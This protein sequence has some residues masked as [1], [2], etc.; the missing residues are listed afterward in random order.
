MNESSD[1]KFVTRNYNFVNDQS[2]TNHIVGKKVLKS[3]YCDYNG[4]YILVR[5]DLT[6]KGLNITQV[7]LQN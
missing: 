3:N 1:S 6:I 4:A 5:N 2:N 7:S